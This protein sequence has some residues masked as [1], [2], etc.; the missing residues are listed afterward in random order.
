MLALPASWDPV[1][2]DDTGRIERIQLAG[3][4]PSTT[5]TVVLSRPL[6]Y[7]V[8]MLDGDAA[9]ENTRRLVLDFAE[10]TLAPDA[11][12]PIQVGNALVRQIRT[13]QFNA[14]TARVV[15]ELARDATHAVDASQSPPQVTIALAGPA[16][17]GAPATG[18]VA[19]APPATAAGSDP[20]PPPAVAA[21]A[22]Q[23]AA[24]PA[25][26]A[27]EP[28]KTPPRTIPIRARGRRPYS[29]MYSR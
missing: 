15:L 12:K 6:A 17:A 11:A 23:P 8:R 19:P 7:D 27:T 18:T 22:S 20:S 4:G 5:V 14:R 24:V 2:A 21:E 13:G 25:A 9:H 1:A 16:A 26:A 10:A 29:L 3:A 28:S